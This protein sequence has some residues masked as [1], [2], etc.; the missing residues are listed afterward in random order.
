MSG[1]QKLQFSPDMLRGLLQ[2][3]QPA[4]KPP[5][6]VEVMTTEGE[7]MCFNVDAIE[8]V[9]EGSDHE[10]ERC[11]FR[12]KGLKEYVGAE[13][14]YDQFLKAIDVTPRCLASGEADPGG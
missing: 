3:P 5:E 7:R 13:M 4:Q 11:Y 9:L 1:P 12:L 10:R 8:L 14:P 2:G 6:V